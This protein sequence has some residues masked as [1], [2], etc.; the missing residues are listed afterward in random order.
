MRRLR[1]VVELVLN[2]IFGLDHFFA[3]L[4]PLHY[5]G[6]AMIGLGAD[7]EID[8]RNASEDFPTFR[9]SNTAGNADKHLPTELVPELADATKLR[10]DLFGGLLTDMTGIEQHKVC[11]FH[12]V[13]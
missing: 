13:R 6:E 8:R 7:H 1:Q 11:F 3:G 9:L 12:L 10:I 4:R 2:R 5:G